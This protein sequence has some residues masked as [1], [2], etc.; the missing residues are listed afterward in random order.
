MSAHHYRIFH[1]DGKLLWDTLTDGMNL[2]APAAQVAEDTVRRHRNKCGCGKAA[3]PQGL[4]C[5]TLH[6]H[7]IFV[8]AVEA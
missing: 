1:D 7:G 2:Y 6:P 8:E 5:G 3:G 4:Y